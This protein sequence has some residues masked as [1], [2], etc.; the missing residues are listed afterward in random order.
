M[1]IAICEFS[2]EG[3][4]FSPELADFARFAPNGWEEPDILLDMYRGTQS[5]LGGMIHVAEREGVD[6]APPA[7]HTRLRRSCATEGSVRAYH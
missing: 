1:K 5:F 2:H 4:S 6:T 3:N 7:H